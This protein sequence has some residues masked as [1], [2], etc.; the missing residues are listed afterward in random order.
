[1]DGISF[2]E[3]EGTEEHEDQRVD[4]EQDLTRQS[5]PNQHGIDPKGQIYPQ[6]T[7]TA[8]SLNRNSH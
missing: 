8:I 6:F 7:K 3:D 5:C 4:W 1:M 2:V